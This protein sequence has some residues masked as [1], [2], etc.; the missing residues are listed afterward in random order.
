MPNS[1]IPPSLQ[2]QRSPA[3]TLVQNRCPPGLHSPTPESSGLST[4]GRD[5]RP[6]AAANVA[7]PP[8][9]RASFQRCVVSGCRHAGSR[10]K[11]F[12][13]SG[14]DKSS[15]WGSS[16]VCFQPAVPGS[17]SPAAPATAPPPLPASP[18]LSATLSAAASCARPF[19]NFIK[20]PDRSF[21]VQ[22]DRKTRDLWRLF[23]SGSARASGP[24]AQ[25]SAQ[26]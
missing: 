23:V 4:L 3:N 20:A 6:R 24:R 19:C 5:T 8:P 22:A 17:T 12:S 11:D 26:P 13:P 2:R 1:C 15:R 18:P 10:L 21:T 14:F 25:R 7:P 16:E 9:P